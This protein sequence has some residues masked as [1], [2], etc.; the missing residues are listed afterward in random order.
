ML[1][2]LLS[3]N[4]ELQ[5]S[6]NYSGVLFLQGSKGFA[7]I[8]NSLALITSTISSRAYGVHA[9]GRSRQDEKVRALM[10]E[11]LVE[12][13]EAAALREEWLAERAQVR[14]R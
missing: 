14:G 10:R 12:S 13:K 2:H 4:D 8:S 3:S 7:N 6:N 9:G 11:A 5:V 1:A